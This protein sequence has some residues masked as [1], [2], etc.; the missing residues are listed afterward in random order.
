MGRGALE[1]FIRVCEAP[2]PLV[3][4][5]SLFLTAV[6]LQVLTYHFHCV[7]SPLCQRLTC[8]LYFNFSP[9]PQETANANR[10]LGPRIFHASPDGLEFNVL[11]RSEATER[12][13]RITKEV[14]GDLAEKVKRENST[15]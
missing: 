11:T 7:G 1:G 2:A 9:I 13:C 5:S 6:R 3:Y 12:H 4:Y 8:R 14:S 10:P 15:N